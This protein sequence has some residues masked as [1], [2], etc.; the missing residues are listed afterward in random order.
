MRRSDLLKPFKS[1]LQIIVIVTLGLAVAACDRLSFN[2]G[3]TV[4]GSGNLKTETRRVSGFSAVTLQGS[5]SLTISVTGTESLT[6]EAEDNLLEYLTSD[7]SDGRL[8][9]G[10]RP[11]TGIQATKGIK[12]MLTVKDLSDLQISGSGDAVLDTINASSFN[13][14]ISGSGSMVINNI[15]TS[16]FNFV[17]NGSGKVTVAGK[18]DN[19]NIQIPGSGSF[20]GTGL[21]SK[22]ATVGCSGSGN[23][24]AKVSDTLNV[25]ISGSGSVQYIGDPVVTKTIPG[26]GSVSK[27]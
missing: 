21:D 17:L 7:V 15:T 12:Y 13:A 5:G 9:L 1:I 16:N 6:I 14:V 25:T 27:Q 11:N 19:L 8:T 10:T 22:T 2:A 24:I 18:A 23:V 26:S 3:N 20:D 4:K